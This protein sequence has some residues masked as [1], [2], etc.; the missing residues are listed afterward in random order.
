MLMRIDPP[1]DMSYIRLNVPPEKI[2]LLSWLITS[3]EGLGHLTTE[4]AKNGTVL[5]LFPPGNGSTMR[6]VLESIADEGIKISIISE[7]FSN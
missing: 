4:D 6:R 2:F 3:Y 5:I 1:D 7:S